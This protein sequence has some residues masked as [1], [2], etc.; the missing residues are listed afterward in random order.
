MKSLRL[1]LIVV[2]FIMVGGACSQSGP[3]VT[4]GGTGGATGI[5]DSGTGTGGSATISVDGL[6]GVPNANG[7]VLK[8]SWMMFP[9][10]AQQGQDCI[11]IAQGACPNQSTTLPFE[12]QGLQFDQSFM[13]GGTPGTMYNMTIQVNGITEAKYYQNGVRADGNASPPN[14]DLL[15]GINTFYTGG[16]PVNFEN[17]NIYKLTVQDTTGTE[18]QHYYLNSLPTGTTTLY[19]NHDTFPEGYTAVIPVMGGGMVLYHQ[20]D[21]NCHAI[22]NC[23][24][25]SRSASCAVTAGRN[26]PNEPN[27]VIPS[28]YLGTPMENFNTRNAA[29][30]PFHAQLMHITVTAVEVMPAAP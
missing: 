15:T 22:D 10:F 16:D 27:V 30:Q 20:A 5:P 12:Q 4:V 29:A 2:P 26:I 23:G 7:D 21:R 24:I 17:Y 11:T 1:A 28:S 9:C 6:A 18:L 13:V 19:E 14:P 8:D 25:G 3:S